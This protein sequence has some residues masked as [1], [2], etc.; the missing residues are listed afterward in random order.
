WLEV[1]LHGLKTN[2]M[3]IGAKITLTVD[4][5]GTPSPIRYREVTSGGSFGASPLL[6][7]IGVGKAKIVKT[8][9]IKWPVSGTTQVFHDVPVDGRIEITELAD[10]YK[11]VP[12]ARFT[13]GAS[14]K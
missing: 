7:H 8:V 9:E 2:R 12:I 11:T 3:A 1:R 13:L 6:Q 5:S 14:A 10:T 4:G